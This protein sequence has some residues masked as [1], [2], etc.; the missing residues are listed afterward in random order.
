M[1][2]YG[3]ASVRINKR[4]DSILPIYSYGLLQKISGTLT[5][6]TP[7]AGKPAQSDIQVVARDFDGDEL[8]AK[9]PF[10]RLDHYNKVKASP[11]FVRITQ[12]NVIVATGLSLHF[13]GSGGHGTYG[14]MVRSSETVYVGYIGRG[15]HAAVIRV[16]GPHNDL[17]LQLTPQPAIGKQFSIGPRVAAGSLCQFS[18]HLIWFTEPTANLGSIDPVTGAIAQHA[19]P[20]GHA[21]D[22]VACPFGTPQFTNPVDFGEISGNAVGFGYSDG[23]LHEIAIPTSNSGLAGIWVDHAPYYDLWFTEASSGKLGNANIEG[24]VS[25]FNAPVGSSPKGIYDGY[26][27]DPALNALG[28]YHSDGGISE[29]TLP[30]PNSQP[31][32]VTTTDAFSPSTVWFSEAGNARLA[33]I[34]NGRIVEYPTRAP[35]GQIASGVDGWVYATDA[36]NNVEMVDPKGNVT[37]IPNPTPGTSLLAITRGFDQD[38]W[39]LA[40]SSTSSTIEEILY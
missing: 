39:V 38:M 30:H 34:A 40:A 15:A 11:L 36:N 23:T 33:T 5:N 7:P 17:A 26:F 12:P 35:L 32:G 4:G 29:Q 25:E 8:P 31:F 19:I 16:Y 9:Q 3:D 24:Y 28:S 27:T 1:L 6:A 10:Y 2:S 13:S 20:S 14:Y 18:S 21:A 37:V 22:F